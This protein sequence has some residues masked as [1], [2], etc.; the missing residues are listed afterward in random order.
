MSVEEARCVHGRCPEE[1][2][3]KIS[4]AD[5]GRTRICYAHVQGKTEMCAGKIPQ[6]A[7]NGDRPRTYQGNHREVRR[8]DAIQNIYRWLP[9]H[10]SEKRL[11]C[12]LTK[13]L[14]KRGMRFVCA[15]V[16]M[17]NPQQRYRTLLSLKKLLLPS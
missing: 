13:C 15:H 1:R 7:Q 16:R 9:A 14:P 2:E 10:M 5:V 12:V 4:C 6:R 3:L 11:R 17:R 8:Q